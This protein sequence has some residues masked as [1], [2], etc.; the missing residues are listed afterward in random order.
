MN[1]PTLSA[2][3]TRV[4]VHGRS[5]RRVGTAVY[6]FSIPAFFL[7]PPTA[8]ARAIVEFWPAIWRNSLFTLW[9][10]LLG[11]ALAVALGL[12]LGLWVGWSRS[13]YAGLYP[14]MIGFNAIPKSRSYRSW[15]C[16]LVSDSC[17]RR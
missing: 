11:L 5:V 1:A 12:G 16:G 7:P 15:F 8:V 4:A 10:T 14:L 17:Q 13:V 2:R 3:L 9:A 6:V